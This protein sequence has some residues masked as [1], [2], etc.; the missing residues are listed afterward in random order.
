VFEE[1]KTSFAARLV[2]AARIVFAVREPPQVVVDLA[3]CCA[4]N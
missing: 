4:S 2:F 1:A 3:V